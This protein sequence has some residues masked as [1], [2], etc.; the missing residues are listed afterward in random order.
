M[1]VRVIIFCLLTALTGATQ[2]F[3]CKALASQ[4][5]SQMQQETLHKAFRAG[6]PDN[7]SYSLAAIA[8]QESSAGVQL[9]NP[10][11]PSSGVFMVTTKNALHYAGW[12]D[13]EANHAVMYEVLQYDFN[14][15]AEYALMNLKWW[16]RLHGDNWKRSWASY[17]SGY[18][19]DSKA[20]RM[21]SKGVEEKVLT[22]AKCG[23]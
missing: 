3:E 1:R 14:T 15:S 6:E 11:D 18:N 13:T 16:V 21:Y 23:W 8:W 4:G 20:G 5:L 7:L 19:W 17:N 9:K 22:V 2:A 10:S 12:E